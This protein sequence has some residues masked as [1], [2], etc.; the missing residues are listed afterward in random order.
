MNY[1]I[2]VENYHN[3]LQDANHNFEYLGVDLKKFERKK[4]NVNDILITYITKIMKFSDMRKV[5]NNEII[6]LPETFKYDLEID[7]CIKTK[8]IQNLNEKNWIY[9]RPILNTL[10]AFKEK[11]MNLVLL[12]APVRIPQEDYDIINKYFKNK[13]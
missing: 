2:I 7:K 4:F 5:I 10:E 11:K 12:N 3:R 6:N 9:S 13:V 8:L 1:W